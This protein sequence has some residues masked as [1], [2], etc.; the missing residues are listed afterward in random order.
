MTIYLLHFDQPFK[1]ARHYLSHTIELEARLAQHRNPEAAR[2]HKVLQGLHAEG[3]TFTVART[4]AGDG[5][6]LRHLDRRGSR[7]RICPICDPRLRVAS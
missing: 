3:G 6:L 4:W 5:T 1:H 2:N 7:A